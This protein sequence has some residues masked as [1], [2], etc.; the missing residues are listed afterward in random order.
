MRTYVDLWNGGHA[1]TDGFR[2]IRNLDRFF[3]DAVTAVVPHTEAA[4]DIEENATHY[5]LNFDVPGVTKENLKIELKENVLTISGERKNLRDEKNK[6]HLVERIHGKF[7]RAVTL[8]T[9]VDANKI[10]AAYRD[11]VLQVSV[12]K[13]EAAKPRQIPIQTLN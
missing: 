9:E 5:L 13:A 4:C 1:L 10:E 11:G 7:Y 2:F 12:P 3:D 8:P 6:S